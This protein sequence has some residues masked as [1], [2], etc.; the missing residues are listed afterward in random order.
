MNGLLA[1]YIRV[2]ETGPIVKRERER[3]R[4]VILEP[5]SWAYCEDKKGDEEYDILGTLLSIRILQ[6]WTI[7]AI[8]QVRQLRLMAVEGLSRSPSDGHPVIG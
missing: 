3:D 7:I 8:L 4:K 1:I 6:I 5:A 2:G